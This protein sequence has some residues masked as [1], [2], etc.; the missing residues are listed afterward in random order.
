MVDDHALIAFRGSI[1]SF[2]S[3]G[4]TCQ[5]G[6]LQPMRFFGVA[7]GLRAIE[8]VTRR[9]NHRREREPKRRDELPR[10]TVP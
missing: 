6:Q 4:T 9:S 1:E 10:G 7:T 2:E 8:P 3:S 5:A